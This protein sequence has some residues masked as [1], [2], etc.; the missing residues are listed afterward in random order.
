[1]I[2][3]VEEELMEGNGFAYYLLI[4]TCCCAEV[5]EVM[6]I[7]HHQVSQ[8]WRRALALAVHS[9]PLQQFGISFGIGWYE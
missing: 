1:M 8:T 3:R 2:S 4:L 9:S 6:E 5:D 7:D